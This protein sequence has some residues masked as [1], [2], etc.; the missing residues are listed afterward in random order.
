MINRRY[1]ELFPAERGFTVACTMPSS[2]RRYPV[3]ISNLML[4]DACCKVNKCADGQRSQTAVDRRQ[5]PFP[6]DFCFG[7]SWPLSRPKTRGDADL[8]APVGFVETDEA[9]SP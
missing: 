8:A 7:L 2:Q 5:H 1:V 6:A 4:P 9:R 3:I